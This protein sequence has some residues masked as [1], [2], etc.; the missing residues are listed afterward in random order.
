MTGES[1]KRSYVIGQTE[2]PARPL[3][4]A[5]YLV[6]TPIGNLA[7]ITLRALETLAA[8]D[9]LACE[10]TRVSRVLL[11]RYGIR[12]RTS[13]Y[14]E[15]N[16]GEAGPKLIAAL[17]AGQS[18]ALISDAGT[19]LISDP[20]YRLVGEAID[21]GIRVVPIPGP[22]APLAAL[23]ASGLPSDAFLFAGFL[24]VKTGQRLTRLEALKTVPAT[25]IFFESPRRLAETLGAMVEALGGARKA[26]IGRE[27][28]K[29]FEEI[30]TGSL[31][32]LADH[33]AAADTPKG[34]IVICVGPSEATADEPADIDRLLRSLAA[35][36]PA[37][38]AAAE[39]A[40]MTGGQ[41]QAL[42]RRLLELK[43]SG[44]DG[45]G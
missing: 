31:Q 35:E 41:K 43:D 6:A 28:T 19:P 25:L 40:K 12:R 32:S 24:P 29:T 33:Y 22:S 45:D 37:S 20:G 36:M 42:Y 27:L 34:E 18:V 16:A 9:I 2:I 44:K 23:T 11:D 14:H 15:H 21:Q 7:D 13:A 39:A 38:K 4:P 26:A 1:A 5:L 30:R 10:D 8:A 17:L 3:E